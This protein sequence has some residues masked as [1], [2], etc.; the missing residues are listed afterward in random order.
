MKRKFFK[1]FRPPYG[2]KAV[3]FSAFDGMSC[4][5]IV[6]NAI[7]GEGNY[8]YLASEVDQSAI[9][10]TQHN[11]PNTVQL[12]DIRKISASKILKQYGHIDMLIG[13]SPC[14]NLSISGNRKGLKNGEVDITSYKQYMR[15]KKEGHEFGEKDQSY[16]FWEF[17]R[18]KKQ[19]KPTIFLL[20]N[21]LMKGSNQ[22]YEE[23]FTKEMGVH[24]V[25][26][27]SMYF[28]GQFRERL[29][30]TNLECGPIPKDIVPL[31]SLIQNAVAGYGQRTQRDK[32]LVGT[33]R[34]IP[35]AN[36]LTTTD[37]CRKYIDS[38][39]VIH[40]HT[41]EQCEALQGVPIGYTDVPGVSQTARFKALGKG[42]TIPVIYH[43]CKKISEEHLEYS[44]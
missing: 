43:F 27:N 18:M 33:T 28:T 2:R 9:K 23:I 44:K 20:E 38:K 30:W 17:V 13:G 39:G 31:S 15:L 26:I 34:T 25:A 14:N 12:G 1:I 7:F 11:F 19:L 6:L 42:W 40:K 21:V 10:I 35:V 3:V 36:C 41:V 24:P 32:G 22:R 16:L 8:I 5:Q 29:Y 37:P 4:G